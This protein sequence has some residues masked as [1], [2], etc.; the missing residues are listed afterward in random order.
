MTKEEAAQLLNNRQYLEEITHEEAK[1]LKQNGLVVVFGYSDDN[2]EFMGALCDEIG[3]NS[4]ARPGGFDIQF[5][6]NGLVPDWPE[7]EKKTKEEADDY[8]RFV[9][10]PNRWITA[11][12]G[13]KGSSYDWEF[14][15]DFPHATFDVFENTVPFC[16]GVVFS[17]DEALNHKPTQTTA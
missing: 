3:A 13:K 1:L 17:L 9:S 11:F 15:C 5:T 6:K 2:V 14:E 4:A 10:K 8:Y 7:H 12:F 16:K